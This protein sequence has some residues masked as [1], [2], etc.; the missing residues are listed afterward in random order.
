[1]SGEYEEWVG[2]LL[3][4]VARLER[5]ESE[6]TAQLKLYHAM[7]DNIN[8]RLDNHQTQIDLLVEIIGTRFFMHSVKA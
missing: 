7:Q 2:D 4:R 1:M 8:A 3:D 6:L 5:R